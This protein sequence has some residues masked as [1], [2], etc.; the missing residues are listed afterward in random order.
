MV[1]R[2]IQLR[3]VQNVDFS[4]TA[5]IELPVGP[6]YHQIVLQVGYA[7]GTNTIAGAAAQ[8]GE[9]RV[10]ANGR[11][12]RT[13]S[14]AQLNALNNANGA[15]YVPFTGEVPNTAPGVCFPIFFAEPW[16][17][18]AADMDRLAWQTRNWTSFQIEVDVP[19]AIASATAGSLTLL[20]WAIVDD[21]YDEKNPVQPIVKWVRHAVA[22]A[23]LVQDISTIDRRDWLQQVSIY[24]P[25]TTGTVNKVTLRVDGNILHELTAAANRSVNFQNGMVPVAT[26]Y[27]LVLDHDGL[28]SS[29]VN[30]NGA[31]DLTFTVEAVAGTAMTGSLTAIVQRIGSPD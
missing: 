13:M 24:D 16:R 2:R 28:L 30:L 3:N 19:A 29:A 4:K 5:L 12:Q 21:F 23:G 26:R 15:A 9:I 7:S 1:K 8:L 31:K 25:S 6:R 14:V 22:A 27:D 17:Q 20:A 18:D 10:K 11:V